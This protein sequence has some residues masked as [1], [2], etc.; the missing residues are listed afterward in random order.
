MD[1]VRQRALQAIEPVV[2]FVVAVGL[3]IAGAGYWALAIGVVA[4]AWA[5]AVVAIVTWPYPLR[6]RY[7][8]G[9]LRVYARFSVPIFIA[10]ACS[11]VLA[12]ATVIATNAHLGLAGVGAVALAATI[13]AFTSRVDDL[14]SGT[15]Y[16]AICAMQNR[17]DLLR[18]SFVKS[19]RLALM[20]AMPF[21]VGLALFSRRSRPLRDRGEM[22]PGGRSCFRSRARGGDQ[23]MIGLQLG[24]LFPGP[25]ETRPIAVASRRLDA[26][27][28]GRRD[29]AALQRTDSS[30]WRSGSPPGRSFSSCF[31]AWYLSHLFEGFSFFRHALRA[32]LPTVPAALAVLLI[33]VVETG[34]RNVAVAIVELIVYVGW[35]SAPP[36]CSSA[37]SSA[38]RSA[39]CPPARCDPVPTAGEAVPPV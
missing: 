36:G 29:S 19:N 3:A 15:L 38:R 28:A 6:W 8:R 4:G 9:A 10:T 17:V 7:D 25:G 18:E 39:I 34:P 26:R 37:R 1:F 33:R 30:A 14:V 24:R 22:A 32:I 20:W 21:G 12:N 23:P 35:W 11:V 31:R 13:T 16:P 27:P 5:G 2:G